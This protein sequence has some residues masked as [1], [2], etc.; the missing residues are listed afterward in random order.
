[1]FWYESSPNGWNRIARNVPAQQ[2]LD[3][4]QNASLFGLINF[5]MADGFIAGLTLSISTISGVRSPRS[6]PETSDGNDQT[7]DDPTWSSFLVAPNIPDYPSTHS[8]LG[9]AAAE[10][11][12]RFFDNDDD[13]IAF[14][15]TSGNPFPGIT[16]P[17]EVLTAG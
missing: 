14:A 11:L 12:A 6:A 15:T 17:Q 9:A 13:E 7:F 5:A 3:L 1:M 8:V 4:W 16:R 10:V 2:G